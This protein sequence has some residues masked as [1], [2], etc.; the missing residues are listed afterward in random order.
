MGWTI[1]PRLAAGAIV[2]ALALAMVI[3]YFAVARAKPAVTPADAYAIQAREYEAI[4]ARATGDPGRGLYKAPK[5]FP[6]P[7]KLPSA[8]TESRDK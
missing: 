6:M 3:G 2:A 5:G 7:G 1:P 8:A 4:A